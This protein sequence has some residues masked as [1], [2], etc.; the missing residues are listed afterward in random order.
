MRW[1][2]G[3]EMRWWVVVSR[4]DRDTSCVSMLDRAISSLLRLASSRRTES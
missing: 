2:V 4:L 1:M 3:V